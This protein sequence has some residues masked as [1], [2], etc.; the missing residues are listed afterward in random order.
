ML[1][2]AQFLAHYRKNQHRRFEEERTSQELL[3]APEHPSPVSVRDALVYRDDALSPVKQIPNMHKGE[4]AKDSHD[5]QSED[6]WNLADNL[7]N[8]MTSV[9][10][11]EINRRKLQNIENLVQKLRRLNSTHNEAS[12]DYIASL[13]ENPNPDHRYISEI[14][15]AS[16]LLLRDLG[17]GLTTFQLHPSGY[18]INPELFMVLGANQGQQFSFKRRM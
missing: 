5:Q 13:C 6:Q 9:L 8:S 17:S 4:G 2:E 12:T 1:P 3:V 11:S 18:P 15:L 10:S 14:L 16:G 7:S